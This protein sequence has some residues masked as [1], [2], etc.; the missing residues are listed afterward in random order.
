M[1]R[2]SGWRRVTAR[3]LVV[4]PCALAGPAI[5]VGV[6]PGGIAV[7]HAVAVGNVLGVLAGEVC[8]SG[9]TQHRGAEA[10]LS[11]LGMRVETLQ[12]RLVEGDVN[13]FQRQLHTKVPEPEPTP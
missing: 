13:G 3:R 4:S 5:E 9:F 6:N 11:H 12:E 2:D 7:A 10:P 8:G 1:R